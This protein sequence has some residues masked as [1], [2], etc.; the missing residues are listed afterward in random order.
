MI[1][2]VGDVAKIRPV[3]GSNQN[4]SH[5][6][7]IFGAVYMNDAARS[8]A[9]ETKPTYAA[10]AIILREKLS[11]PS[12]KTPDTLS[13]MVKHERGFNPLAND[14]EFLVVSGDGTRLV[15]REKTGSCQQCH[16]SASDNDFV[17]RGY[18]P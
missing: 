11:T 12:A 7:W 10:G 3:S 6:G 17:F 2:P 1:A 18:A 4:D 9:R 8:A 13:V 5:A 14:W 16:S 15:K